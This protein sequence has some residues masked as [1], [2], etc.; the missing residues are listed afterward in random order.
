MVPDSLLSVFDEYE[1]EVTFSGFCVSCSV[2]MVLFFLGLCSI[3]MLLFCKF[4]TRIWFTHRLNAT[5]HTVPL[6]VWLTL[7][8]GPNHQ[9]ILHNR[10]RLL[11]GWVLFCPKGFRCWCVR[12][13]ITTTDNKRQTREKGGK[14]MSEDRVPIFNFLTP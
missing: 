14:K 1:L 3:Q 5:Q 2:L 9:Q 12:K 8:H 4:R 10:A 11:N 13:Y 7:S 6:P